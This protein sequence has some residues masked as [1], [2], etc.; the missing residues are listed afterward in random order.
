VSGGVVSDVD[1]EVVID[2]EGDGEVR[3]SPASH[4]Y[5]ERSTRGM[6]SQKDRNNKPLFAMPL[7]PPV[8]NALF[9]GIAIHI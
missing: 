8:E 1:G 5:T 7:Q 4:P 3:V 2:C 6:T 9:S